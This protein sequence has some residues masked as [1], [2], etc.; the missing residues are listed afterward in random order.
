MSQR[1]HARRFLKLLKYKQKKK[2]EGGVDEFGEEE[3]E[4]KKTKHQA[5]PLFKYD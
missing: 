1:C 3:E 2:K 4:E 5:K